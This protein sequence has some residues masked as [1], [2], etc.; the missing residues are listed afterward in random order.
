VVTG[1]SVLVESSL[2]NFR[3]EFE[4]HI[5]QHRCPYQ[6]LAVGVA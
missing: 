4:E 1:A 5:A 2:R 6:P 3:H